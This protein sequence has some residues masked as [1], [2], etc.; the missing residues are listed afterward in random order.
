MQRFQVHS[1]LATPKFSLKQEKDEI[2]V[3]N[4]M[5]PVP[6]ACLARASSELSCTF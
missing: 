2:R 5:T 3:C 1:W 4:I 6:G